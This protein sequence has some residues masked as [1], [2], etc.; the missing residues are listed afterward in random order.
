LVEIGG[1]TRVQ[2]PNFQVLKITKKSETNNISSVISATFLK[3]H[4]AASGG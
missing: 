1:K 3:T 4:I 2:S